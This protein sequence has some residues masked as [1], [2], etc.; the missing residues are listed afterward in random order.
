[1]LD[2]CMAARGDRQR[3]VAGG[4]C[5][6]PRT[7]VLGTLPPGGG[8]NLRTLTHLGGGVDPPSKKF[9]TLGAGGLTPLTVSAI[10]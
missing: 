8:A 9:N 5:L 2:G 4:P 7:W 6:S 10:L 3:R 1:M